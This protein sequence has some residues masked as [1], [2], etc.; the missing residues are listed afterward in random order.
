M[1]KFN[2]LGNI[3]AD[4]PYIIIYGNNQPQYIPQPIESTYDTWNP[5]LTEDFPYTLN[6]NTPQTNTG[7]QT[8]ANQVSCT[9]LV[10]TAYLD[11]TGNCRCHNDTI[12]STDTVKV[13]DSQNGQPVIYTTAKV[14]VQNQVDITDTIKSNLLLIGLALVAILILKGGK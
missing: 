5:I 4:Y 7:N 11:E 1:S 10:G 2:K 12:N 6:N 14:P 9:C 8:M 13:I 3:P